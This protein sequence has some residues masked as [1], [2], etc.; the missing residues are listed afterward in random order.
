MQ[1]SAQAGIMDASYIKIISAFRMIFASSEPI[2]MED[3]DDGRTGTG[4]P[5]NLCIVV[6]S[7][8]SKA[9]IPVQAHAKATLL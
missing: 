9:D 4:R 8:I 3:T 6:P 5:N 7:F 1:S 2:L